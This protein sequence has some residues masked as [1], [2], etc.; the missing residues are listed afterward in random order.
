MTDS[1][2][3]SVSTEN[4][5]IEELQQQLLTASEKKQL[6]AIDRLSGLGEPGLTVLKEFL[7]GGRDREPNLVLGKTYQCLYQNPL[8]QD[9]L[10]AHFP[11][12]IVPFNSEL[13]ID[14]KPLQQALLTQDFQTADRITL[15]KL[16]ELA[17]EAAIERKWLY[18]SEVDKFP[19]ADLQ[20]IDRLWLLHS[21]GKFGFS[22]QREIWLSNRKDF[23]KVWSKIGWKAEKNW[24]RYPNEF[25][26]DLSAPKGHLPLSNQLRGVRA[27]ASLLSH[28]A[29]STP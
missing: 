28:P 4:R 24:T 14:Y 18:F 27:F 17:G 12:G 15:Q 25:T 3:T 22:V 13:N 29:W 2:R 5:E 11:H 23:S 1:T 16:C 9:F 26:W 6:Q 21:E 7:Q 8:T 20:T 10:L 19:I